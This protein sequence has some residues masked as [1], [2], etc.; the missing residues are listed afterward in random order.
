[1]RLGKFKV[2]AITVRSQRLQNRLAAIFDYRQRRVNEED[3]M[4]VMSFNTMDGIFT[5][6]LLIIDDAPEPP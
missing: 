6:A 2:V 5:P 4:A 3:S 1:M